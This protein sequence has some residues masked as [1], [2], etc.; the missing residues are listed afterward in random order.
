MQQG[1]GIVARLDR[2][3][4]Y[5]AIDGKPV[6]L[7][8]LLLSPADG[9]APGNSQHLA[10]LAAVSRRLRDAGASASLRAAKSSVALRAILIGAA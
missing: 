1:E 2:A 5:A 3:I 10:A 8:F 4:D 9:A 6:D 7:V